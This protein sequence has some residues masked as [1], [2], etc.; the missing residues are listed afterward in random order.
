MRKDTYVAGLGLPT[1]EQTECG[2]TIH[3]SI[4]LAASPVNCA[5]CSLV[6]IQLGCTNA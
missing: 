2:N 4:R 3:R 1:P 5:S 6:D